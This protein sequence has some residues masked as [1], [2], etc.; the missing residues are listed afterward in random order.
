[1]I[2]LSQRFQDRI[3]SLWGSQLSR[4]REKKGPSGRI[5]KPGY[6]LPFNKKQFVAWFVDIFGGEFGVIRCRYCN[7][8]IDAFNCVV[9][10]STPLKRGGPPALHNLD[11][12]CEEDNQI[13]GQMTPDEFTWFLNKMAEMSARFPGSP[14]VRDITSRLQK[15]IKLAAAVRFG[16]ASRQK[17][18][19]A[20]VV[21]QDD[22]NF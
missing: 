7:R 12:I 10:H 17:K 20:A 2:A 6:E 4:S 18:A 21:Q 5:S 1:M 14:C 13:K 9:D 16:I 3:D 8:P 22:D 11:V 15:A 19:V